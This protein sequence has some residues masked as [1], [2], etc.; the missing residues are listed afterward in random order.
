MKQ[1]S[2]K[3]DKDQESMQS[4]IMTAEMADINDK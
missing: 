2:K 4:F 3:G 1:Q